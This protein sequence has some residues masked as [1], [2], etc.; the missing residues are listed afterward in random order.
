MTTSQAQG[1]IKFIS[2]LFTHQGCTHKRLILIVRRTPFN[3]QNDPVRCLVGATGAYRVVRPTTSCRMAYT[4]QNCEKA[5]RQLSAK[6][7]E[8]VIEAISGISRFILPLRG[9]AALCRCEKSGRDSKNLGAE[10]MRFEV[11]DFPVVVANDIY[12]NDL[13]K[14]GVAKYE[15]KLSG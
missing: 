11:I 14:E 1:E 9:A 10:V 8:L 13:Y 15:R 12:G 3:V 4:R 5:L 6:P 2:G 7:F